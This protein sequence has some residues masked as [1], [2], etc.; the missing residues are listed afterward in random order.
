MSV[1]FEIKNA[2]GCLVAKKLD[3]ISETEKPPGDVFFFLEINSSFSISEIT[4][5]VP[6]EEIEKRGLRDN[7]VLLLR[8]TEYGWVWDSGG[9]KVGEDEVFNY[10]QAF[11]LYSPKGKG[12]YA[13]SFIPEKEKWIIP[14]PRI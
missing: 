1:E 3:K 14:H 13:V 6:K 8:L 9:G 12:Y 7:D 11:L 4:Y 5:A 10:Y 2:S